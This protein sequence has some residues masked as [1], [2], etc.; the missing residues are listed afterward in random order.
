VTAGPDLI[1]PNVHELAELTGRPLRML[2]DVLEA[3][4]TVRDKGVTTVVV[5]LGADGAILVDPDGAWHAS[6]APVT[7][8]SAVGA[9][10]AMVAGL[11]AADGHGPEALR[12]G[13]AFG[14]AAA[15]LPGTQ[16]PRLE[17]LDL[18]A[19]TVGEVIPDRELTEPGGSR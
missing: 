1:K 6:T 5:S 3:A 15:R 17:D 4:H 9:G 14:V 2:G 10:D 12:R 18:D 11:L 19:V 16:F 7:V 13:V 8:R